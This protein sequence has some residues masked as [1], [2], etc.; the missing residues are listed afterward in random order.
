DS[1]ATEHARLRATA[2]PEDKYTGPKNLSAKAPAD[3][4]ELAKQFVEQHGQESV[5]PRIEFL[6]KKTRLLP[7]ERAQLAALKSLDTKGS[8]GSETASPEEISKR[9]L[10]PGYLKGEKPTE[11]DHAVLANR[12]LLMHGD[13]GVSKK[14]LQLEG[15]KRLSPGDRAT[16]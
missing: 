10:S 4:S 3:S 14:I 9:P 15:R 11:S 5:Q 2:K 7:G 13:A 8:S 6:E 12:Y 16:L 1:S